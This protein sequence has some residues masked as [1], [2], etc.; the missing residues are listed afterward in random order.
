MLF[1][2]VTPLD[3]EVV[4]PMSPADLTRIYAEGINRGDDAVKRKGS[5]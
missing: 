3:L 5:H 4:A 2:P 1:A